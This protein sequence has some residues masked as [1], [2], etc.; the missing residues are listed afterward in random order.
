M[1]NT[2]QA[3][4]LCALA[5]QNSFQNL[6]VRYSRVMSGGGGPVY[7]A[8]TAVLLTECTK[9]AVSVVALA[10]SSGSLTG[11]PAHVT[12][13][14]T[15]AN[16][17]KLL[18]PAALYILQN[19]LV[20]YCLS[21]LDAPTYQ[22]L[23][24]LKLLTTAGFSAL[25]LRKRLHRVQKIAL[26]LLVAGVSV[27]YACGD[28]HVETAGGEQSLSS[29]MRGVAGAVGVAISSGFAGVYL[30]YVMKRT[31]ETPVSP[32]IIN[33]YMS[34]YGV[35]SAA[36][37]VYAK[38]GSVVTERGLLSGYNGVVALMIL[39]SAAG[40]VLTSIVISILDN[41]YKNFA[42]AVAVYISA[43]VSVVFFGIALVRL[44]LP[45]HS[46]SSCAMRVSSCFAFA[47]FAATAAHV[48][49]S[50]VKLQEA[51]FF[52]GSTVV[53]CSVLLYND[54]LVSRDFRGNGSSA[55]VASASAD[56]KMVYSRRA[57]SHRTDLP[58]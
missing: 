56:A 52:V 49:A 5:L 25:F 34:L 9:V 32:H 16:S 51:K 35:V 57:P 14:L 7:I 55:A 27:F 21:H 2:Q 4:A 46:F 13:Q 43:F 42:V 11:L 3:G 33:L 24:Q 31:R 12:Q 23:A 20:I 6:I 37:T 53:A 10:S 36:A 40:G 17:L 18:L 38:D 8:S 26:V 30:E 22:V 45:F 44:H 48:S 41:I 47:W 58:A 1:L 29:T 50:C 15:P 39:S 28:T 19:N 54:E